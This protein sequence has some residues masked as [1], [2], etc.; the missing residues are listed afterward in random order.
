K[1][2]FEPFNELWNNRDYFGYNIWD[3]NAPLYRQIWQGLSRTIGEQTDAMSVSGPKPAP[4]LSAPKF[5]PN[6]EP[7]RHPSKLFEAL[8]AKGVDM[9]M[10][11]F[12]PA[13]T[14]VEKSAIQNRI[15]YLYREHVA[16]ASKPHTDEENTREKN[17]VRSAIMIAKRD[18]DAGLM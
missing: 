16:A 3:E 11:G 18:H 2:L 8:Q 5:P 10:L 13:P 12:G 15:G 6:L 4:E 17:A 9:S 1:M 7:Q 14:Y